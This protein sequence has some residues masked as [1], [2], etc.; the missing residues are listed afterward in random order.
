MKLYHS[1]LLAL[2]SLSAVV[3]S[4]NNTDDEDVLVAR[5]GNRVLTW[6]ELQ[7]VIPDNSTIEDSA[8]LAESYINNWVKEQLIISEAE[9]NLTD[10]KQKF[11]DLIENYRKSLLTYAYEQEFVNKWLDTTVSSSEI[12][13]YYNNN[14]NNFQLKDF[15]VKVKYCAINSDNKQLRNLKKFFLSSEPGDLVKWQ[16]LCVEEGASYYFNEENWMLFD[17][18]L[19][20]VPLKVYDIE[21]FLRK[22]KNIEFEKDNNLYLITITNYQLSGSISPLSFEKQKIRDLILNKRKLDLISQMREEIYNTALKENK[23][24]YYY[25]KQ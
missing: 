8:M 4:C 13:Q 25:K 6:E 5:A 17:E 24:E 19:K 14:I 23:I 3:F 2:I 21:A 16:Q 22:N 9:N 20:Q 11:D 7:S 15:I 12:E 1:G 10:E 18:F